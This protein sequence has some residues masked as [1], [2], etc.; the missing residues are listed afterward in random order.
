M[1]LVQDLVFNGYNIPTLAL[2][3]LIVEVVLFCGL[4]VGWYFGARR[5]NITLHHWMVY[6]ATIA[7]L[8][9]WL[10][11][12]LPNALRAAPRVLADPLG[13]WIPFAHWTMGSITIALSL[14]ITI[15]FAVK[16]FEIRLRTLI[17]FRPLMIA[18]VICWTITLFLGLLVFLT[19]KVRPIATP[20]NLIQSLNVILYYL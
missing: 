15:S 13:R 17:N 18:T 7:H 12:M 11:V 19:V 6:G 8:T 20:E 4:F 16:R 5:L 14:F 3:V 1:T 10:L 2:L 9:V